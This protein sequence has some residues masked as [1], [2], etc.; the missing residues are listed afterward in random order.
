[1]ISAPWK[2]TT[3]G[4]MSFNDECAHSGGDEGGECDEYELMLRAH[5]SHRRV[6]ASDTKDES[7][8]SRERQRCRR[9]ERREI[10]ER[11]RSRESRDGY[12][13][14]PSPGRYPLPSSWLHHGNLGQGR[15]LRSGD[16]GTERRPQPG[17]TRVAPSPRR[18]NADGMPRV[19][20]PYGCVSSAGI[21]RPNA[22]ALDSRQLTAE[23][24][25][26]HALP[27]LLYLHERYGHRFNRFHLNA[28]WNRFKK[29]PHGELGGLSDC[30]APVCERTVRMLPELDGR[31]VASVAHAFAKAK[32]VGAG[33]WQ[34][35]W[36]AL[37]QGA[38]RGLRDFNAQN[39]QHGVGVR[40]RGP[41]DACA[42][43]C[44]LR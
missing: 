41:R 38:R 35:V 4:K 15:A 7:C 26:A 34:D 19:S 2:A 8:A 21:S 42:L 6:P 17:Y 16:R 12:G 31:G 18:T 11:S 20:A 1:M 23:L 22:V 30:L 33:A 25:K 32:L 44:H 3:T 24:G 28:F 39:L 29:L 10:R 9:D 5:V 43:W 37:D 40:Y 13:R 14:P 27:E 36:V